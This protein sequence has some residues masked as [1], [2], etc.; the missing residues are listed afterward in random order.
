MLTARSRVGV[1]IVLMALLSALPLAAQS[2]V[3]NYGL[4]LVGQYDTGLVVGGTLGPRLAAGMGLGR[5]L[6]LEAGVSMRKFI[7]W[8]AAADLGLLWTPLSVS[9]W[10]PELGLAA[11]VSYCSLV[12]LDSGAG[13]TV[14]PVG[15]QGVASAGLRV[16]P[17][18]FR[19]PAYSFSA[20]G[21]SLWWRW[22]AFGNWPAIGCELFGLS[23]PVGGAP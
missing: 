17:F 10:Q 19:F 20:L 18:Q 14:W 1:P 8:E 4:G 16:R 13:V 9:V 3:W 21:L 15:P 12:V 23:F 5:D 22:A 11:A 2:A 6:S 7:G